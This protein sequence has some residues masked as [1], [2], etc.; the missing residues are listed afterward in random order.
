MPVRGVDHD[1]IDARGDQP[2]DPLLGA[3]AHADRRADQQPALLVLA[4][5]RM[6]GRLEHVLDGHQALELHRIVD[7]QHALEPVLVHQRFGGLEIGAFPDCDQLVARRHHPAH[8]LVEIRL[9]AQVTVGDNAD[10]LVAFD[11]RQAGNPALLRQR[12]HFAHRHA[13][14]H[15]DRILDDARLETLDLRDLGRLLGG[16]EILVDDAQ[17]AFLRQ[18]D[19]QACFGD[20]IH[21]RGE[22]R[23]VERDGAGEAGG[24]TDFA[25]ND[26]RVSRNEQNVVEGQRFLDYAHLFPLAQKR[27]IR[28]LSRQA[29]RF[30]P[31]REPVPCCLAGVPAASNR[32]V[33][34]LR[35]GAWA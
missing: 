11:H 9:E 14:R 31:V 28:T 13:G 23:D 25:W 26:G 30:G 16:R 6:L 29:Y 35:L 12:D 8:G 5:I 27:I 1:H 2:L 34:L 24:E 21:R 20:G 10:N 3:R 17:A 15:G 33:C 7:H 19:C 32:Q 4:R 18:R 22:Q